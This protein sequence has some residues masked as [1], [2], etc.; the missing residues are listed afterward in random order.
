[1]VRSP[2]YFTAL[3]DQK[4]D[5]NAGDEAFKALIFFGKATRT[6][7]LKSLTYNHHPS[8]QAMSSLYPPLSFINNPNK[9]P[10]HGGLRWGMA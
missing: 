3:V 8:T 5:I 9:L 4:T 2:K 1:M 6:Q 10:K 7:P